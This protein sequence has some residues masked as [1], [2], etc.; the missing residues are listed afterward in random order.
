MRTG[1]LNPLI[2]QLIPDLCDDMI[3]RVIGGVHFGKKWKHFVRIAQQALKR[4]GIIVRS[5][6]GHWVM[7]QSDYSHNPS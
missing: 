4:D 6:T 5:E 7:V 1:E 2:Q 3:D